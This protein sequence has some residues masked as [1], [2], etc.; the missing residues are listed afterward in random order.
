MSINF[1]DES[2]RHRYKDFSG[3]SDILRDYSYD[4]QDEIVKY[5]N[6]SADNCVSELKRTSPINKRNVK[7]KGR[8]AKSWGVSTGNVYNKNRG[9]HEYSIIVHNKKD[10][11][12]THLLEYPHLTRNGNRTTPSSA[13]HIYNAEQNAIKEFETNLEKAIKGGI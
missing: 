11:Q 10:Y 9:I 13:G 5:A 8:Y 3:L 7:N 1:Y 4:I 2:G 6:E 12:L